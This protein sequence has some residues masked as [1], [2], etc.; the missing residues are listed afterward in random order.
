[1][2][3]LNENKKVVDEGLKLYPNLIRMQCSDAEDA[4]T[5]E[6]EKL[7]RVLESIDRFAIDNSNS[8]KAIDAVKAHLNEY[9]LVITAQKSACEGDIFDYRKFKEYVKSEIL[10]G[11]EINEKYRYA[12]HMYNENMEK[13][14]RYMKIYEADISPCANHYL[15]QSR[16]YENLA[17]TYKMQ[18]TV[19]EEKG[20]ELTEINELTADPIST[21]KALKAKVKSGLSALG[22]AFDGSTFKS[23]IG[24]EWINGINSDM[25]NMAQ[26]MAIGNGDLKGKSDAEI[27]RICKKPYADMTTLEKMEWQNIENYIVNCNIDSK[28]KVDFINLVLKSCTLKK[29]KLANSAIDEYEFNDKIPRINKALYSNLTVNSPDSKIRNSV[30]WGYLQKTSSI[31]GIPRINMRDVGYDEYMVKDCIDVTVYDKRTFFSPQYSEEK[32]EYTIFPIRNIKQELGRADIEK[33]YSTAK[34]DQI[35]KKIK[36]NTAATALMGVG[37]LP[38][39]YGMTIPFSIVSTY[40]DEKANAKTH[41]NTASFV[42]SL[43]NLPKGNCKG[44]IVE[45]PKYYPHLELLSDNK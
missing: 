7:D 3:R 34:G 16:N 8:G 38:V 37:E 32:L 27:A 29:G 18:A 2:N 11:D 41:Y 28:K 33:H 40:F 15:S 5:K 35:E 42:A 23:C 6:M 36:I 17:N 31:C 1:M 44:M 13:A 14:E 26:K 25:K 12:A 20:Q 24:S 43:S 19:W 30:I 9:K 4:L 45:N 39:K 22:R 10:L 21:S